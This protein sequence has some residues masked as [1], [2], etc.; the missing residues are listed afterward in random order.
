M[1]SITSARWTALTL[2]IVGIAAAVSSLAGAWGPG[3]DKVGA[4]AGAVAAV[5]GPA[6]RLIGEW[7]WQTTP[8]GQASYG[9]PTVVPSAG[10]V[11]AEISAAVQPESAVKPDPPQ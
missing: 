10:Q 9:P 5:A 2:F 3:L 8:A 1:K 11:D 7:I 6:M 4:I